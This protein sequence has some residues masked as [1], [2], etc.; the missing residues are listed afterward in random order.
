MSFVIDAIGCT[1]S[2]FFAN[3]MRPSVSSTMAAVDFTS[4]W[5]GS[6]LPW[7]DATWTNRLVRMFLG[8]ALAERIERA[9]GF[10]V[11]LALVALVFPVLLVVA[12]STAGA[13]RNS[14]SNP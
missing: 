6:S 3:S 2:M 1:E 14:A 11:R 5:V 4:R 10:A 8:A 7:V 12:A 9:A 13:H